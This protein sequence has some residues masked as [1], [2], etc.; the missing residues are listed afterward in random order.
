LPQNPEN[1]R[2]LPQ[3]D[4]RA[5]RA[6][7]ADEVFADAPSGGEAP[8]DPLDEEAWDGL[9]VL[10]TDV[11]LRTSDNRG[12]LL[13]DCHEQ[14]KAWIR[15]T[16]LEED[17]GEFIFAPAL[18][19]GDEFSASPVI[20]AHGYYRQAT[21]GLRNALEAMAHSAAF[22]VSG[23][24]HAFQKW[25]Q[26]TQD[27]KFGNAVDQL[28]QDKGLAA[29]DAKLGGA[30]LFG[31]RP[32]GVLYVTYSN[33]CRYVHG[34]AGATNFDIWQSNGPVFNWH[35]FTQFWIDFCDT[36]ALCYVLGKIAWDNLELPDAAPPLFE[37]ADERWNGLGRLAMR[38][39][40]A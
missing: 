23:D 17:G 21:A 29:I 30:G 24:G 3:G 2:A 9:F 18:D 31:R 16:P 37:F 26:G 34:E 38:E 12:T 7:L 14:I 39:F 19:A 33:L 22:A 4:F 5:E 35:G 27:P 6:Y 15:A 1:F 25:R 36:V 10:P 20:A 28:G 32:D 8:T 13:D 11:L 40:F